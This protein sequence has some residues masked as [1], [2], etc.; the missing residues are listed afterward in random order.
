MKTSVNNL[1][2]NLLKCMNNETDFIILCLGSKKCI[3]DTLG[4]VVGSLLKYKYKISNYCYGDFN[5][6]VTS[7]NLDEIVAFINYKHHAK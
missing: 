4:C 2:L 6:N 7:K 3:G 5:N 1:S